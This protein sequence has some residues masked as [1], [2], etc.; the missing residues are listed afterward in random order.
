FTPERE[1]DAGGC[2]VC[3]GLVD[4]CARLREPGLEHKATIASETRAA[5]RAGIT[6]LCTPPDTTPVIDT[7]AVIELV[8]QRAAE[9][10][11]ARVE[12]VGALTR[13]LEGTYLSEMGAL[14]AAGCVGV[15]NGGRPIASTAV[16]RRAL[17]YAA[18]FDLTVFVWPEDPWLAGD[19]RVHEGALST[20][21]G[22]PGIPETA[23][24][25]T[26]ARDLLLAEQ[27]GA[28]VHFCRLSSARAVDMVRETRARGLPVT[29]DVSAHHLHLAESDVAAFDSLCHVRP[30]LR[31]EAD[32][33]GLRAAVAAGTVTA[34]CSDHQ[35]HERDAKLN[36]FIETEPGISG[37][38]T[39]LPL[40]L[41][42]VDE[43]AAA[44]STVLDCVSAG[45]AR[46]LGRPL[47]TLGAGSPADVCVFD[48]DARWRLDDAS[49]VS[50][51]HNTPFLGQI[52]RGRVTHTILAG[53]IVHEATE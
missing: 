40:A 14:G 27:T 48:P 21:L 10:G 36:P 38:E 50:R 9:V 19:G 7:P 45:P 35:P 42:L 5:A 46:I 17:E 43:G 8:H 3:P 34:I 6:T 12:V 23:E 33:A 32:R 31:T 22:L 2:I 13:E 18:T 26:L 11:L 1:I 51:G 28:R 24:T 39:L 49:M 4:L 41:R 44:L 20:R 37:L 53:R 52:L 15:G 30:P 16:M 25:V 47:G 29:A